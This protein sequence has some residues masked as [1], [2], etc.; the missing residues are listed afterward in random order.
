[1]SGKSDTEEH[2]REHANMKDKKRQECEYVRE[3]ERKNVQSDI[4]GR[5]KNSMI[6]EEPELEDSALARSVM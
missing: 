6:A 1:M 2:V 5:P 4:C 3:R